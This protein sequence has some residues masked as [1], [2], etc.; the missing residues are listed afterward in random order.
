MLYQLL[1]L[2]VIFGNFF[3]P[4]ISLVI[5]VLDNIVVFSTD[6]SFFIYFSKP[7][8]FFILGYYYIYFKLIVKI[9]I[10]QRIQVPMMINQNNY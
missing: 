5:E 1:W 9:N 8:L 3:K 10:K 4:V 7:S 2:Y 6:F